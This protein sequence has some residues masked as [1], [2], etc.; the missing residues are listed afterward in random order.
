MAGDKKRLIKKVELRDFKLNALLDITKAINSNADTS[1]L[2]SLYEKVLRED[3][4]INKLLLFK[5]EESWK[6]ILQVG[7]EGD[8]FEIADEEF[9]NDN[10]NAGLQLTQKEESQS[11][12]MIVPVYQDDKPIAQLLAGD[13]EEQRGM[14]P[15]VKHMRF[16]QTI[17]SIVVVAIEN[18]K[19]L[20]DSIRQE[21]MKKELE[22]AAELQ[23]LLVPGELPKNEIFDVSA[24]YMPHQQVG[25]DYYDFIELDDDRSI[26]CMADVSGKGVSAAF[27]MANFQ[28]YL[29]AIYTH[30]DMSLEEVI[31]EL[32]TRVMDSAMGEKY[33][34][35]FIA[36]YQK[37]TRKLEYINC[38]HNPPIL[39][40]DNQTHLLS[41]GSIGLG[42]FDEIPT[43]SKGEMV[44]ETESFLVCYTDGLVEL[45]NTELAEYGVERLEILM[46]NFKEKTMAELNELILNEIDEYRGDMPYVDDTAI[47]SCRFF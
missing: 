29:R 1:T 46:M 44:L 45:E 42:M 39:L 35:F 3:L 43:L 21:R 26:I 10:S 17:T 32:N 23:A 16:L 7:V 4:G 33:I 2:L 28:A 24:V 40:N 11:F 38:G 5:K 31:R 27:L 20:L 14:S 18:K 9:F 36:C 6:C 41:L 34:T 8:V 37:S 47:L 13:K 19:L 12:D 25:G 30:A 15:V 22:L